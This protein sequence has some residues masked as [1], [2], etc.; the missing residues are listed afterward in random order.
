V[1]GPAAIL[2]HRTAFA[3]QTLCGNPVSCSAGRAVLDTIAAEG[4]VENAAARGLELA[5]GLRRLAD[6]HEAIGDIRGRGLA[7]GVELVENRESRAPAGSL[8]Q[9]VVYRSWEL[10]LLLFYVGARSNVLEITPAL[11]ITT[12]EIEEGLAVLDLALQDA[13]SGRVDA[14]AVAAY[15]GW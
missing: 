11:T 9:A 10:G 8:C 6:R 3:M 14:A 5:N 2:D 7:V 15:A 12:A 4:L 1:V 13:S